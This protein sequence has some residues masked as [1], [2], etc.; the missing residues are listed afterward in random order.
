MG[1]TPILCT[2][3]GDCEFEPRRSHHK[4]TIHNIRYILM[5]EQSSSN[6]PAKSVRLRLGNGYNIA[7]WYL[8]SARLAQLGEHHPYKLGVGGS[9]PS[10]GTTLYSWFHLP[11]RLKH[12]GPVLAIEIPRLY[13]TKRLPYN[14][15]IST[16]NSPPAAF[17][18]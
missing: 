9:R 18:G 17:I 15:W 4:G 13:V 8:L 10:P 3:G 16:I 7:Q 14:W 11:K 1:S 6:L 12:T 5:L 2:K